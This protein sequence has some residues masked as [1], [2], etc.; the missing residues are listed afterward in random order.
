MESDERRMAFL[1]RAS[2]MLQHETDFA[3]PMDAGTRTRLARLSRDFAKAMDV[4]AAAAEAERVCRTAYDKARRA[5][6]GVAL[7]YQTMMCLLHTDET[8]P[9]VGPPVCLYADD[10]DDVLL[11][12]ADDL[13]R[14]WS[15]STLRLADRRAAD[16]AG[17][18]EALLPRFSNARMA[19]RRAERRRRAAERVLVRRRAELREMRLRLH[20][21][22]VAFFGALPLEVCRLRLRQIGLQ[23]AF[24]TADAGTEEA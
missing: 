8:E 2:L 4:A 22:L 24:E 15:R 12:N 23:Q 20:A 10:P 19:L 6:S 21:L 17:M 3:V 11:D 13:W 7:H 18:L 14:Y 1:T 9:L 16:T 5:L